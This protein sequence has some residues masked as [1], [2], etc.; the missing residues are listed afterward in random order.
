MNHNILNRISEKYIEQ[1]IKE[2][3]DQIYAYFFDSYEDRIRMNKIHLNMVKANSKKELYLKIFYDN[4][5]EI[6][7]C[8]VYH[9]SDDLIIKKIANNTSLDR[10]NIGYSNRLARSYYGDYRGITNWQN[11]IM[12]NKEYVENLIYKYIKD[13]IAGIDGLHLNKFDIC[14]TKNVIYI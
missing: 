13:V 5:E 2:N 4:F 10:Y 14:L 7:L 8:F 6:L 12:D 11:D 1:R 3:N 9:N